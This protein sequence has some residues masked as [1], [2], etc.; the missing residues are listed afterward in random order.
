MRHALVTGGAGF[1]GSHLVDRLLAEGWTV[2]AIDNFDSYYDPAVKMRNVTPHLGNKAFRL[3]EIDVCDLQ[4]LKSLLHDDYDVIV[5]LAAMAGVRRSIEEPMK[6]QEVNVVGTQAMLE[7]ARE[8]GVPQFV[9]ASSSSVYGVNA[10][11]PWQEHESEL[12][13][14]SPYAASKVAGEVLGRVYSHIHGIRFVGLRLFTVYGP[15]QR[16]DLAIHRFAA[17][18]M[19]GRPIEIYGDGQSAR[20]YIYVEDVVDGI[21]GAMLYTDSMCEIVNLAGSCPIRIIDVVRTLED[22]LGTR[23]AVV[24]QEERVGDA[25][26]TWGHIDKAQRLLGYSPRTDFR[27]GVERFVQWLGASGGVERVGRG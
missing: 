18:M 10:Q 23:A 19:A 9:F 3:L 24:R 22:V 25:C 27:T 7:V 15:R 8:L 14:I 2:T 20:D 13:P 5:H 21:I 4:R 26:M 6:Y 12:L 16:P 11:M 1:I 17:N